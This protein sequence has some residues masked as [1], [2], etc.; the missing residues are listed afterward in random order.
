METRKL[1]SYFFKNRAS[2]NK[3]SAK[4]KEGAKVLAIGIIAL[5][6]FGIFTTSQRLNAG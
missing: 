1:W 6:A 5:F 3:A 4:I 2:E